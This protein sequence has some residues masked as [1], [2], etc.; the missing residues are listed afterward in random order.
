MGLACVTSL[1]H[2]IDVFG[3]QLMTVVWVLDEGKWEAARF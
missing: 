3:S 2:D 1:Q